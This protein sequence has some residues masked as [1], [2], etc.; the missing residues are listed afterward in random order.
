MKKQKRKIVTH[1]ERHLYRVEWLQ[2]DGTW[3]VYFIA[4]FRAWTGEPFEKRLSGD[5]KTARELL[6]E[7]HWLNNH[8][9]PLVLKAERE[10]QEK[11]N[12]LTLRKWAPLARAL[13]EVK[14]KRSLGR[15]KELHDHIV[16]IMGDKLLTEITR[17]D[18]FA[19]LE[20]RRGETLYRCGKWTDIPVS[21]GTIR[22]EL[23]A[24]RRLLNLAADHGV[25]TAA[26]RF[27]GV[28]P[29][30]THRPRT[31]KEPERQR[32]LKE[33][34][35]WLRR[36]L[37]VALETCLS[38]GDLIRLEDTDVDYEGGVIT[39]KGGRK[40]TG[41]FQ[42]SPL[43]PVVRQILADISAERK[44]EKVASITNLVFTKDG[45]PI[46][47]NMIHKALGKACKR[48]NVSDF[49]FHDTRHT[50]T[51][52]WADAGIPVEAAM[53][54]AGHSS[55]QMHIEYTHLQRSNVAKA[56]GTATSCVVVVERENARQGK[57]RQSESR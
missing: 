32:L 13:P 33:S 18:L 28:L 52:R 53:L 26:V 21:D 10:A 35:L 50:A 42:I 16:R 23:A 39:P 2:L 47:G 51:T 44:S 36:L 5:L 3:S 8:R 24:L 57:K 1:I 22:N 29:D 55:V 41:A 37:V 48:A 27:M 20:K 6:T 14:G 54:A 45:K 7:Y 30:A 9:E 25:K 43:T 11:R 12:V 49:R 34:P 38:R 31:L 15:D 4:R 46:T 56:F 17:D 40:K 19:Y